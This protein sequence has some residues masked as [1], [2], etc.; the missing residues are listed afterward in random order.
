MARQ[1]E[2]SKKNS[3]FKVQ[4]DNAKAFYAIK[5]KF[6]STKFTGYEEVTGNAKLLAK[7]EMDGQFFLVFDKTPFYGESGGQEGDKGE[8]FSQEGKLASIT[9]TQKPV[10]GLHVHISTDACEKN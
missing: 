8:V 6:G 5:E 2:L 9:D 10:D 1:K 3:K 4:E 7:E